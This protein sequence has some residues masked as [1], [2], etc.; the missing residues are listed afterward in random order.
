MRSKAA[1]RT[2]SDGRLKGTPDFTEVCEFERS[3]NGLVPL[4][5]AIFQKWVF[6]R[7]A[8]DGPSLDEYLGADLSTYLPRLMGDKHWMERRRYALD[9]NWKVFVDNYLDG[10]YHIPIV[11][12]GLDSVLNYSEYAIETG[13]RFC[14]QSSP[15]GL[16][17]G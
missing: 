5:C 12:P 6:A 1:G 13:E 11:H 3:A 16:D 7:I 4:D 10:G 15:M 2:P 9:C 17:G 14:L 8:A